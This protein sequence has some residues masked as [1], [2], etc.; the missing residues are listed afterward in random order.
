[1]KGRVE[2][3]VLADAPDSSS[4]S[5]GGGGGADLGGPELIL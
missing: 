4:S 1:M 5:G 2:M 3:N